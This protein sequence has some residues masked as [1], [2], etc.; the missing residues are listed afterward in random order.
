MKDVDRGAL[1][2][3]AALAG[4]AGYVDAIG[5][6]DTG[7]L[8]V[9]FMSGN[10]TQAAVEVFGPG[11]A[12]ALASAGIIAAFVFGV[13]VG[14]VAATLLARPRAWIVG[15]ATVAVAL[16][17]V[18]A[19]GGETTLWRVAL[20]AAGMGALNT[21]FLA[22]GRA[23]VAITYSTGTLVSLGLALAA[24]ATGGSRR[25][26]RR[27]LLLW[28]SLVGGAV[29]G[30]VAHRGGSPFALSFAAVV[31]TI[32]TVILAVRPSATERGPSAER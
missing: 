29:V 4:V 22:D 27:P 17:A 20:L 23:R 24:A 8:F 32:V 28:S 15:G 14:G 26:W 6:L 31:L 19:F 18:L 7:G 11:A 16:V 3:S 13:A 2:I 12:V 5:F 25:A 9:S 1:A 21:L 10:S 30:A